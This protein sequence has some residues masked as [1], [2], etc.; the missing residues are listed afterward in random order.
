MN[1]DED[2]IK[3]TFGEKADYFYEQMRTDSS[4]DD[5]IKGLYNCSYFRLDYNS[6]RIGRCF[7][8]KFLFLVFIINNYRC[9]GNC[10]DFYWNKCL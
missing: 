1:E 2:L 4:S 5:E 9:Y 10:F 8:E 3:Q 6:G 7:C